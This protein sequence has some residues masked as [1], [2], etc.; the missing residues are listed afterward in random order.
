NLN[1]NSKVCRSMLLACMAL[2]ATLLLP[3]C[4]TTG[5]APARE[6]VTRELPN[7]P[8]YLQPAAVPPATEGVSPF[9][10]S[11]QRKAVIERQNYVIVRAKDAWQTMKRTYSKSLIRKGV[12]GSR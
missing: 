10:V 7:P 5:N 1:S 4:A 6:P 3:G 11:E 2:V 8:S 12:F 9:V